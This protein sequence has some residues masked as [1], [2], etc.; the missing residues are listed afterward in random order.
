MKS[1]QYDFEIRLGNEIVGVSRGAT[2]SGAKDNFVL[3]NKFKQIRKVMKEEQEQEQFGKGRARKLSAEPI[4]RTPE[5][6]PPA[7]KFQGFQKKNRKV[8]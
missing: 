2:A 4:G 3:S 5:T 8:G 1:K 7:K 6:R